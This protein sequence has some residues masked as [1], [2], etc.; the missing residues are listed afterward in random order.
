MTIMTWV[1]K[2]KLAKIIMVQINQR[3]LKVLLT[4]V[5][6][7][8]IL[9]THSSKLSNY[10]RIWLIYRLD[11]QNPTTRDLETTS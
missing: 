3:E 7:I 8:Q 11:C 2:V 5:K 6:K 4:N 9:K 10:Q 1:E